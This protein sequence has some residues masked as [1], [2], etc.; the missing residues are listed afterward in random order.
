MLAALDEKQKREQEEDNKTKLSAAA[1]PFYPL[2]AVLNQLGVRTTDSTDPLSATDPLG[3]AALGLTNITNALG[4]TNSATIGATL[5]VGNSS[6]GTSLPNQL[7]NTI[8]NPIGSKIPSA[9][10]R[11]V[12]SATIA[13]VVDGAS[14]PGYK[15]AD[16][17]DDPFAR[18][19]PFNM[20]SL[21]SPG[22]RESPVL[23][24]TP[25]IT[26]EP[27]KFYRA[28]VCAR[29]DACYFLHPADPQ[30][31]IRTDIRHLSPANPI[32]F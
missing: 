15:S 8:S 10:E 31:E 5:G 6:L 22:T 16:P 12:T 29:G 20:A 28:G 3:T 1:T 25:P 26:E 13:G 2:S 30:L 18:L 14:G 7:N 23:R 19:S 24:N 9:W 21:L 32:F 11:L 4:T 17:G 27:C